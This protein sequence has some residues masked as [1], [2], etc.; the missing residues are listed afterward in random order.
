MT[1]SQNVDTVNKALKTR[2]FGSSSNSNTGNTGSSQANKA[3]NQGDLTITRGGDI[4]PLVVKSIKVELL[5][6][7]ELVEGKVLTSF[8]VKGSASDVLVECLNHFEEISTSCG[9]DSRIIQELNV[10]GLLTPVAVS[11]RKVKGPDEVALRNKVYG[12]LVDFR[13]NNLIPTTL[14]LAHKSKTV[15]FVMEGNSLWFTAYE[16]CSFLEYIL[17]AQAAGEDEVV[18]EPNVNVSSEFFRKFKFPKA[19]A[20]KAEARKVEEDRRSAEDF[21]K[22]LERLAEEEEEEKRLSEVKEELGLQGRVKDALTQVKARI[23]KG[24][25]LNKATKEKGAPQRLL[26]E[27]REEGDKLLQEYECLMAYV[28]NTDSKK[29]KQIKNLLNLKPMELRGKKEE[30]RQAADLL[31]C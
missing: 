19:E 5:P 16:A 20:L 25:A 17:E 2:D 26:M 9:K 3:K 1:A 4:K 30:L 6:E 15:E 7:F 21:V 18:L 22:A 23:A 11:L 31:G 13:D 29:V 10:G 27:M 28:L 12:D 8:D 24:E 14:H